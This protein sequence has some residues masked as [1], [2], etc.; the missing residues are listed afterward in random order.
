MMLCYVNINIKHVFHYD[1]FKNSTYIKILVQTQPLQRSSSSLWR[2][3]PST[4]T[5]LGRTICST[6]LDLREGT[7]CE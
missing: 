3:L 5:P 1:L 7:G 4:S 6:P 2:S